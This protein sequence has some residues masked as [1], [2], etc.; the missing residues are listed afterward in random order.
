ML[1]VLRNPVF[2]KMLTVQIFALAGTGLLTVAL[3]LLAF[4]LAQGNAGVVLGT[5]LTIKMLAYV[6]LAPL[7]NAIA[8][9]VPAKTLL[10]CADIVR[11]AVAACLIFVETVWQVYVA[12]FALQAASA[13][14]TPTFQATIPEI[15]PD[16]EDYT[17]AL[18][19]SR[20]ATELE[21]LLSPLFAGLLLMVLS[22]HWLF[23]GTVVG[24]TVSA[25]M[26]LTT[27]LPAPV[28]PSQSDSFRS[29][30]T[31][32]ARI[33][34]QTPRLRGL[35]GLNVTVAA[36][37]AFIFVNTVVLVRSGY[38]RSEADVA[39]ALA[40]FGTGAA[41]SA[42]S[43]PRL[44]TRLS[45]RTVM[46][47]AGSALCLLA[48]GHAA[49]MLTLGLLGWPM[50]LVVWF[51]YGVGFSA[52]TTPSGRLLIRSSQCE[53]RRSI[54]VA[55]FALSHACWLIT[56]PLAGWAGAALGL[57]ETLA[58]LGVLALVGLLAALKAWPAEEEAT[59]PHDHPELPPDHP[60]LREHRDAS[61]A[62]AHAYF[63]DNIH[64]TWPSR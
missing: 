15:L 61:G 45:D 51:A 13:V 59:L 25:V 34:L 9:R 2:A 55:Q 17:K 47:A 4:D 19:L 6:G 36:V 64:R 57:P 33:Y 44:L 29:R 48:L 8:G 31:N 46:T 62:H 24:F 12:I 10:V 14:F 30:L 58:M 16:E 52:I 32:G 27:V 22:F 39:I 43:L 28:P 26:I 60:H 21:N 3:A 7:A 11:A 54:F 38:G 18:S 53:D 23:A 56:Y 37:G 63:I 1:G 50:F 20:L 41:L 42:L 49:I 40:A 35:L 5:A